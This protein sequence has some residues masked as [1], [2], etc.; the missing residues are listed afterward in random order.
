MIYNQ[1][2]VSILIEDMEKIKNVFFTNGVFILG[3]E[4]EIGTNRFFRDKGELAKFI[5]KIID[6]MMN[7]LLYT[8]R[9]IFRDTLENLNE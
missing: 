9:V 4:G 8:T 1:T 7:I 2:P 5:D 6:Y 3:D